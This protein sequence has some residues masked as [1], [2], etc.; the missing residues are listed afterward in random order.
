MMSAV[1]VSTSG[2]SLNAI[3]YAMPTIVPGSA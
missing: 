3:K 2:R 1:P